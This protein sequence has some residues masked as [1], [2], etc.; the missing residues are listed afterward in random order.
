M[1]SEILPPAPLSP[2]TKKEK[3]KKRLVKGRLLRHRLL[4][5]CH[6]LLSW[7]MFQSRN[8]HPVPNQASKVCHSVKSGVRFSSGRE[9]TPSDFPVECGPVAGTSFTLDIPMQ[10]KGEWSWFGKYLHL[11]TF[12]KKFFFSFIYSSAV[13]PSF[14]LEPLGGRWKSMAGLADPSVTWLWFESGSRVFSP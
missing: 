5:F 9:V 14:L 11:H 1:L 10:N 8:F 3:S 4:S 12:W 2:P 13:L 7:V 6:G